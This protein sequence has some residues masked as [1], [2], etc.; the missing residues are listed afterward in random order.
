MWTLA[1]E[2]FDDCLTLPVPDANLPDGDWPSQGDWTTAAWQQIPF[3]GWRYEVLEGVLYRSPMPSTVH[4]YCSG[5]I[6]YQLGKYLHRT[7][8]ASGI[9]LM[10]RLAVVLPTASVF[11]DLVY[12]HRK[13][14]DVL[15][16]SGIQGVPDLIIEITSPGTVGYERREKQDTYAR[17]GIPEYWW[18]DP[19][20]RT[21]EVLVLQDGAYI[22]HALVTGQQPIP[23]VQIPGLHFATDDIFMPRDLER[24]LSLS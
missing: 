4:Q 22:P 24:R 20:N 10:A 7:E 8:P 1:P 21:V 9:L 11:P 12:I 17:S 6:A 13:N 14:I 19:A 5:A 2:S 15:T 16:H 23:S 18:V 3:N